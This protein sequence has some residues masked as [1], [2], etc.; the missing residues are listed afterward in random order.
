MEVIP[1]E[2]CQ[3]WVRIIDVEDFVEGPTEADK[4]SVLHCEQPLAVPEMQ[5]FEA[6]RKGELRGERHSENFEAT[7]DKDV[8]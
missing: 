4:D 6:N 2:G 3:F 1:T 7:V 5:E 8:W